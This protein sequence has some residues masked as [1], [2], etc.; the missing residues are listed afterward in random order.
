[1]FTHVSLE[2]AS[3]IVFLTPK[4]AFVGHLLEP[5]AVGNLTFCVP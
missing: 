5:A 4:V 2:E 1:M 3:L